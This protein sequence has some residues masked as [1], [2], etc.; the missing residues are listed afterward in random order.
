MG[1]WRRTNI[2][3]IATVN[4]GQ[5]PDSNFVNEVEYGTPF[6]QGNAEFGTRKPAEVFW[7]TRPRKIAQKEDILVSV[8]A[9]VGE[10]NIAD[11]EYCIGRGLAAVNFWGLNKL[12]A[13]YAFSSVVPQLHIKSQGTTFLAV[14]KGDI[15]KAI[16]SYPIS[17][18]EQSKIAE[19]LSTV[20]EAIDKTR[21]LIEKYKNIKAGMM[22]DLLT[23]GIDKNG[24]IRSIKTNSYKNSEIGQI[25]SEWD[26]GLITTVT[27]KIW[28][29][30]VTS[31][32]K[33]YVNEGVMLI[34]NNNI[35]PGE[36][37]TTDIIYLDV[38]F[39]LQNKGRMLKENDLVTV[40][41]GD[42]GTTAIIDSSTAGSH[43]FATINTRLNRSKMLP[44]FLMFYYNSDI[45]KRRIQSMATG[46]GRNNFNLYDYTKC[47]VPIPELTEQERIVEV[48]R[49]IDIKSQNEKNYLTKLQD[50]KQGLMQ[51]LLTNTV[52]VDALL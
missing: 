10:V 12:F 51:D 26:C 3:E 9:P 5:S 21:A 27:E 37:I 32:T 41:T 18:I 20:D 33:H 48:I 1:E 17:A 30:L 11:K 15:D 47:Y 13:S 44:D 50:I 4:M 2:K 52:S 22:Q 36:I 38:K 24:N 6:L 31:M 16:I 8:R 42:I 43:G 14:S 49:E 45:Y 39:A 19:I 7:C 29:G 23:N 28:I 35:K 40:H 46:D 34:R 25:P